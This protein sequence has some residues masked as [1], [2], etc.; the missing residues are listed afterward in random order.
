MPPPVYGALK[1]VPAMFSRNRMLSKL[2][3][4]RLVHFDHPDKLAGH[5]V[6]WDD[7]W[8]RS[9][10][11]SPARRAAL[12][13]MWV[14]QFAPQSAFHGL[15]IEDQGQLVATLPL[16]SKRLGKMI[17]VGGMPTGVWCACGDLL[18]DPSADAEAVLSLLVDAIDDLPWP[19]L[20][21][22][23]VALDTDHWKRFQQVASQRG[24]GV[25]ADER[26]EIGRLVVNGDWKNYVSSLSKSQ[27][28]SIRRTIDKANRAGDVQLECHTEIAQGQVRN[29]ITRGFEVEQRSWKAN[30]KTTIIDT[31]G[32]AEFLL[33]QSECLAK[34][35]HLRVAFLNWND[36]SIA[37]ELGWSAKGVYHS[38][39]ISFDNDFADFSPG[40]LLFCLLLEQAHDQ[41]QYRAFDLMGPINDSQ[42]R[43]HP[44]TYR[45]G[46][47][48]IAPQR[49][50]GRLLLHA[51]RHAV[52]AVRRWRHRCS[53]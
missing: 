44:E 16:V 7:L 40:H 25:L 31:P 23:G 33:R 41:Q 35:G 10:G 45:L 48:L 3:G 4:L 28:R 14:R 39:K 12:V 29:L 47:M 22:D 1:P 26:F 36:K 20:W 13:E 46:R 19:L 52:P 53:S 9:E 50:S 42:T 32:M 6:A 51:Y 37:Y 2:S 27:R 34:Q 8:L 15:A 17:D 49:T 11:T 24:M 38:F 5:A 43:W 18:L 30:G 21:L